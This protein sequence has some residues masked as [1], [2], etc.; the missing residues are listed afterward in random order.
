VKSWYD[1]AIGMDVICKG[2]FAVTNKDDLTLFSFRIP[3]ETAI[4]FS[5][6]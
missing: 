2:D 6:I 4:D 5:V 1:V 3:S